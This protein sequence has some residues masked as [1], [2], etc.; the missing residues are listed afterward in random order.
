VMELL[1]GGDLDR[2]PGCPWSADQAIATIEQVL[3]GLEHAHH[4]G[5]VHRDLKPENIFLSKDFRGDEIVK[6]V[7]FGI[8]KLLD[9]RGSE[10]LTRQGIVF[11]TPRYMSPEQ[12]AG[13]KIDARTDLYAVGLILF[14]LLAGRPPFETDDPAQL[15]R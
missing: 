1:E 14:E 8:A 5:I 13:G 7:D 10:K 2:Q 9:E 6:I 12:A 11:G 4:V 3:L 15:L